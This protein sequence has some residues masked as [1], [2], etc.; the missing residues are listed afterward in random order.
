[1][2]EAIGGINRHKRRRS[3]EIEAD[4]AET[5][6]LVGTEPCFDRQLIDEATFQT[7]NP[8]AVRTFGG[9]AYGKGEGWKL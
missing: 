3:L 7:T 8:A 1:M 2:S 6:Y 9:A 5:S 4:T